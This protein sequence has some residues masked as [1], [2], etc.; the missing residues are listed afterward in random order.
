MRPSTFCRRTIVSLAFLGIGVLALLPRTAAAQTKDVP[1]AEVDQA[2]PDAVFHPGGKMTIDSA[3]NFKIDPNTPIKDLLPA[4]PTNQPQ[5]MPFVGEDLSQVPEIAF[6]QPYVVKPSG[7]PE[8]L[9]QFPFGQIQDEHTKAIAHQIAKIK[10]ANQKDPDAFLKALVAHRPDLAGLSFAMGDACR[11]K[12][13]QRADF[14]LGLTIL[15]T[16]LK[17][18]VPEGGIH[19]LIQPEAATA[20]MFWNAYQDQWTKHDKKTLVKYPFPQERLNAAHIASLVQVLMPESTTMRQGLAKY[21]SGIPNVEATRALARLAIF[22]PEKEVR[23]EAIKAL[24]VRREKDYADILLAGLQYP[25]APV[26][27]RAGQA[28][29]QLECTGV[30]PRL[31]TMLDD[32]DPRLPVATKVNGKDTFVAK[33]MVR[34]NHHRNC[35][36]CHAPVDAAAVAEN[37]KAVAFGGLAMDPLGVVTLSAPVPSPSQSLGGPEG[38]GNSI[39]DILVRVDVTYLRQDFSIRQSVE[40][41]SPWPK[42]QRFDFLVRKIQLTPAQATAYRTNLQPKAGELSPYQQTLLTTLRDLTGRDAGPN[43][44]AWRKELKLPS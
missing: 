11:M 4:P 8:P 22:S 10:F 12:K 41:A 39:P 32:P 38:Y 3:F 7:Q 18:T 21:L 43:A 2:G 30:V 31:V 25:W 15:R 26:A 14:Q 24:K 40:N 13:E 44:A 35:L 1:S 5:P 42:M 6:Q 16:S 29:A 33:Q 20:A 28:L 36:M 37:F 34:L 9:T 17:Q 27:Q 23:Q 19:G